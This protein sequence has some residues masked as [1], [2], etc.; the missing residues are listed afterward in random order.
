MKRLCNAIAQTCP[1]T[2]KLS[3]VQELLEEPYSW[4][5][6]TTIR[7]L[8]STRSRTLLRK[9]LRCTFGPPLPYRLVSS[10]L[11]SIKMQPTST[12]Y[13]P[14]WRDLTGIPNSTNGRHWP[15]VDKSGS[16]II[17]LEWLLMTL[18]VFGSTKSMI[19]GV[20]YMAVLR[21]SQ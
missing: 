14:G 21:C 9:T 1:K 13:D 8:D 3:S 15:F 17:Y 5:L 16:S 10:R 20:L 19:K 7:R 6:H 18:H 12:G 4:S 11:D 2:S